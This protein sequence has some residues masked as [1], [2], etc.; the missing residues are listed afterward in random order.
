MTI[1]L[2]IF[3]IALFAVIFFFKNF[4]ASVYFIVMTDIFLKIITYLKANYLR[5]DAFSFF[6]F[7]PEDI[8]AI[9]N[10]FEMGVF[11]EIFMILYLVVY[12]VFEV[13]LIR[14]FVKKKF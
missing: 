12:I 1:Q 13:L 6:N 7:I 14:L 10:S 2:M 3:L 11:N 9:I 4:N 5:A 8:P